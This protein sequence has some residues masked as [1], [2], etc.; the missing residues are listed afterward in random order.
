MPYF[1][2]STYL[3]NSTLINFSLCTT[4]IASWSQIGR[5]GT[6]LGTLVANFGDPFTLVFHNW[7]VGPSIGLQMLLV[8]EALYYVI[9]QPYESTKNLKKCILIRP[10]KA[11][12]LFFKLLRTQVLNYGIF[13]STSEWKVS[14]AKSWKPSSNLPKYNCFALLTFWTN[15]QNI[16][17]YFHV[18]DQP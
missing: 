14:L 17:Q 2:N 4:L 15:I 10:T 8:S 11:S 1:Q 5:Y 6:R 3:D 13:E 12:R 9:G 7:I 18:F 16:H